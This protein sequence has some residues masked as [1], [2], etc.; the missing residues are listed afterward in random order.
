MNRLKS[1]RKALKSKTDVAENVEDKPQD[2]AE[3]SSQDDDDDGMLG[4]VSGTLRRPSF[5]DSNGDFELDQKLD[6]DDDDERSRKSKKKKKKKKKKLDDDD[7]EEMSMRSG[8]SKKKKKKKKVKVDGDDASYTSASSRRKKKKKKRRASKWIGDSERTERSVLESGE[9][10]ESSHKI[11]NSEHFVDDAAAIGEENM[12]EP[13]AGG[14]HKDISESQEEL[15]VLEEKSQEDDGQLSVS[16]GEMYVEEKAKTEDKESEETVP[17]QEVGTEI[18]SYNSDE[19]GSRDEQE[20]EE[21]NETAEAKLRSREAAALKSSEANEETTLASMEEEKE[22]LVENELDAQTSNSSSNED[23]EQPGSEAGSS[24]PAQE[25]VEQLPGAD[26]I[27]DVDEI[28][29]KHEA[30]KMKLQEAVDSLQSEK[31][32]LELTVASLTRQ[33][34]EQSKELENQ[35]TNGDDSLEEEIE[36][37]SKEKAQLIESTQTLEVEKTELHEAAD[38]LKAEKDALEATIATLNEDLQEQRQDTDILR[39]QLS[40]AL[41]SQ[42]SKDDAATKIV[43]LQEELSRVVAEKTALAEELQDS[44]DSYKALVAGKN[45]LEENVY[46]LKEQL[47]EQEEQNKILQEELSYAREQGSSSPGETSSQQVGEQTGELATM[48]KQLEDALDINARLEKQL[49]EAAAGETA[50][51]GIAELEEEMK[52]ILEEKVKLEETV[53]SQ[54]DRMEKLEDIIETQLERIETLE[55]ELVAVEDEMFKVRV[56]AFFAQYVAHSF[57]FTLFQMEEELKQLEGGQSKR[58]EYMETVKAE[59]LTRQ[60]SLRMERQS[61]QRL[62]NLSTPTADGLNRGKPRDFG[63]GMDA[64]TEDVTDLKKELEEKEKLIADLEK[65]CKS[66]RAEEKARDEDLRLIQEDIDVKFRKLEKHNTELRAKLEKAQKKAATVHDLEK[67]TT[68]LKEKVKN[69]DKSEQEEKSPA[70]ASTGETKH[71]EILAREQRIIELEEEL[72]AAKKVAEFESSDEYV[73]RLKKEVKAYKEGHRNLKRKVKAEQQDALKRSRKKDATIQ[74]LQKEMIKMRK[75]V[76]FRLTQQKSKRNSVKHSM[77][78]VAQQQMQD[79]EEEIAHWKGANIE[80]E[81]E[82]SKLRE[83]ANEWKTRAKQGGYTDENDDEDDLSAD[84]ESVLSFRSRLSQISKPFFQDD[85]STASSLFVSP[86]KDLEKTPSGGGLRTLG[87]LWNRLKTPQGAAA[88]NPAIP[89]TS[90]LLDD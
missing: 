29:E 85:V 61:S 60:T 33:V 17:T 57:I 71:G 66:L 45:N 3:N 40:E 84:D 10:S 6:E 14:D 77:K 88:Q 51:S 72:E 16:D 90:G 43:E 46:A 67:S 70:A 8:R 55:N 19:A 89:Y 63:L 73:E 82:V 49:D 36:R 76:E 69:E 59:R 58:E 25:E 68:S 52:L 42:M 38:D 31:E 86:L 28:S 34:E 12:M 75:D 50:E 79:L 37:I 11:E 78:D 53:D 47:T 32:K 27:L 24:N 74:F 48:Q 4:V 83:E 5:T 39:Q 35:G 56:P 9:E 13:D 1:I 62:L 44:K 7:S 26:E 81:G 80:L 23:L 41:D 2:N 65:E 87:G 64:I 15:D 21:E 18:S 20:D 30:E 54:D 22:N